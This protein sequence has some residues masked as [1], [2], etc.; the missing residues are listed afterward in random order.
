MVEGV[1]V[2][3]QSFSILLVCGSKGFL[4]CGVFDV[5]AIDSFGQAACLVEST[6]QNPIGTLERF[7]HRKITR[8]NTKA[9]ALGIVEGM[10]VAQAF[11]KIA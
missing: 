3:W 5:D 9:R 1:Q 4:G 7:P 10:D 8:V 6:P 2:K 11:E